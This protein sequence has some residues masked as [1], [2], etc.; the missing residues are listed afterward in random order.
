MASQFFTAAY[1][2]NGKQVINPSFF[3]VNTIFIL[4]KTPMCSSFT[5]STEII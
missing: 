4:F 5:T 1:I 2:T 3:Y